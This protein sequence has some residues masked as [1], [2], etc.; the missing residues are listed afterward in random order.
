MKLTMDLGPH[1][2]DIVIKRGVLA[3]AGLLANLTG[4]VMLVTDAG[5]PE[6][7]VK[8]L[9]AQCGQP[10]VHTLPVGKGT[11]TMETAQDLHRHLLQAGFCR[12]D[13]LAALGG[14]TVGDVAGFAA[15][16][17]RHGMALLQ[18]PTTTTAQCDSAIGGLNFLDLGDFNDM[19]GTLHQPAFVVVDPDLLAT[20]PARHFAS[21]LA[22]A[23]KTALVA[24]GDLFA[25]LEHAVI[26]ENI[27][28]ILYLSLL[29]KKNI[30]E[31][32]EEGTDERLLLRFG[33]TLG[34]GIEAAGKPS[35]FLHGEAVALGLLP[36]VESRALA[37]RARAVMRRL[38]LPLKHPYTPAQ[39][40]PY[41]QNDATHQEGA[42]IVTR[43]KTLGQGYLERMIEEELS[44]LVS[45]R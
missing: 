14:G 22:Q 27:E 40:W 15:S 29:C 11:K 4:R 6:S 10:V 38:G 13:T 21:G 42:F 41:I 8:T 9:A 37:R 35:A 39:L 7:Y 25:I 44:L 18:F 36:F 45:G 31:R 28:R 5:V 12:N 19:L 26:E 23:L 30:I 16:T 20:L 32:D 33:H 17:Y 43:V 24:S 3:R 34:Q 1:S 2:Y